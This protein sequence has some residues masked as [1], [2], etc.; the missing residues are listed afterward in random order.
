[1]SVSSSREWHSSEHALTCDVLLNC[2]MRDNPCSAIRLNRRVNG[3]SQA[4]VIPRSLVQLSRMFGSNLKHTE[5]N[6]R[7]LDGTSLG[8]QATHERSHAAGRCQQAEH[9]VFDDYVSWSIEH[10]VTNMWSS[11]TWHERRCV[12]HGQGIGDD[13]QE[14]VQ[15]SFT[16]KISESGARKGSVGEWGLCH[17]AASFDVMSSTT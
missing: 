6:T 3:T 15:N 10:R 12:A 2:L 7:C 13:T 1:M 17:G 9:P 4:L 8:L 14:L 5:K 11:L 16:P